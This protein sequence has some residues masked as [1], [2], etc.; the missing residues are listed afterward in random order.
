MYRTVSDEE[1]KIEEAYA[2]A[3]QW[4]ARWNELSESGKEHTRA[5]D[6]AYRKATFWLHRLNQLE[7]R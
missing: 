6:E 5:A 1:L 4:L 3:Q 7:G 2:R